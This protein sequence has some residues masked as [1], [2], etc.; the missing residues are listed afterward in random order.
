MI[1]GTIQGDTRSLD[2]G[3]CRSEK[4]FAR[5]QGSLQ[6]VYSGCVCINK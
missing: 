3:S 5:V 6:E 1:L 2:Y 4:T